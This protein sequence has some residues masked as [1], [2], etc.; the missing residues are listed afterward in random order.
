VSKGSIIPIGG[1]EEKVR[2]AAIL[3]R[4]AELSGGDKARIAIIPT[5]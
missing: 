2:D 3:N 1:A 4:F 5:A